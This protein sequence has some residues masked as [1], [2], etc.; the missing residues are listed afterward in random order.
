MFGGGVTAFKTV[1]KKYIQKIIGIIFSPG[2]QEDIFI[3]IFIFSLYKA[4]Y[5]QQRTL[6][7]TQDHYDVTNFGTKKKTADGGGFSKKQ[8]L[9]ISNVQRWTKC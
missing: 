9:T 3:L 7:D 4:Y 6:P 8:S 2:T 5:K 1:D